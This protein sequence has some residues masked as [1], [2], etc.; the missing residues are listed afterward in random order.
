MLGRDLSL[1]GEQS[2]HI[3]FSDYLFTGDGLCTALNVLRTVLLSGRTLA[4]L[5]SD[6]TTYPQVLLNVRVREKVDLKSVPAVAEAIAR[7][8]APRRGP[9]PAARPLLGY[10]AAAPRDARRAEAGRDSRLGAGDRRRREGASGLGA[11]GRG[12]GWRLGTRGWGTGSGSSQRKRE[13]SRDAAQ[14]ARR[15]AC[16]ACSTQYACASMRARPASP[17]IRAPTSGTSRRTTSATS[18]VAARAR[19]ARRAIEFNIEGDP[20]PD[21]LD[22]VDDVRPDQCTLVPVVPGEVTSQ[23][24]WRPGPA[25]ERLPR[26]D[27]AAA[28]ARRPRQPVRRR[29]AGADPVGRVGRRRPRR[30][31]H[32]AVRARVRAR[33]GRRA[34]LVRALRRGG[35]ARARRSASASTPATI[36]T[37]TTSCCSATLPFLD[38]VSIGHAII[39]RAVFVGLDDRRPRVPRRC[40][41][42][43]AE[44]RTRGHDRTASDARAVRLRYDRHFTMKSDAIAFG[45][46]GVLF[47]LIAGWVIGSQQAGR[48]RRRRPPPPAAAAPAPGGAG[49]PRARRSSTRRKVTALEDR[50]RARTVQR[51]AARRA[52]QPL[53]RCRALR[54]CDQVVRGGAEARCRTTST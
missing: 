31:L 7:V 23:A 19:R 41:A 25:T 1:G 3:I 29:D 47:G 8:E 11:R 14:L 35:A 16:R 36:S 10:R 39:S 21:L 33:R 27:R 12:W 17:S 50:R 48:A 45:I 51:E 18:H 42:A 22:L 49:G 26:V 40:L 4:D 37:S 20:R 24:G 44:R 34:A 32:R 54:R 43:R 30:A 38:E 9:G 46:A 53:L 52:R 2:G 6:L 13:Q 15:T 5:A 28:R